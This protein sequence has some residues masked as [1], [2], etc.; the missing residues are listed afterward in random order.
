MAASL[1][2][3]YTCIKDAFTP[4]PHAASDGDFMCA[5]IDIIRPSQKE[6]ATLK[7]A[8]RDVLNQTAF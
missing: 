8:K 3:T 5:P 4:P 6:M 2:E 1:R 7:S